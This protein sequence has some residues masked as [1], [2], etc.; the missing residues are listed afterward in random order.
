MLISGKRGWSSISPSGLEYTEC[1]SSKDVVGV[2]LNANKTTTAIAVALFRFDSLHFIQ[3]VEGV[4][5]L[6]VSQLET[7][8]LYMATIRRDSGEVFQF[9]VKVLNATGGG[10]RERLLAHWLVS[11]R[12]QIHASASEET[13]R[14]PGWISSPA[15]SG[16]WAILP[17]RGSRECPRR[18]LWKC[19]TGSPLSGGDRRARVSAR[20]SSRCWSGRPR[21]A[22]RWAR[23]RGNSTISSIWP[24]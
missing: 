15:G 16:Q 21:T 23:C 18:R 10:G 1:F 7:L 5:R 24:F 11:I 20:A 22:R 2:V 14:C 3:E 17:Q 6:T 19:F 13:V 12:M 9:A 8:C 4:E